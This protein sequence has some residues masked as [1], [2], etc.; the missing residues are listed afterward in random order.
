MEDIEIHAAA[1]KL[2]EWFD[3]DVEAPSPEDEESK[4]APDRNSGRNGSSNGT[5]SN[6]PAKATR[7]EKPA[8]PKGETRSAATSPWALRSKA[9]MTS[10]RI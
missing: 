2:A 4:S 6:T 8:E 9:S 3:L 5:K 7:A 10:T 1:L